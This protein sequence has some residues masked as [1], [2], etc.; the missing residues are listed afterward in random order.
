MSRA[1][2]D[3]WF[4]QRR[5]AFEG[6]L[7]ARF[8]A[9]QQIR[10]PQVLLTHTDANIPADGVGTVPDALA[11]VTTDNGDGWSTLNFTIGGPWLAAL[12][13]NN[14]G[15]SK[16]IGYEIVM[17]VREAGKLYQKVPKVEGPEKYRLHGWVE[18]V[19]MPA[20]TIVA[21]AWA[22]TTRLASATWRV[23]NT[24]ISK[25]WRG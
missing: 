6:K 14:Y 11:R 10:W 7:E 22:A 15:S 2:A 9:L 24:P 4:E 18:I 13:V 25:L 19:P 8:N 5:D 1:A 3:A 12:E 17:Y 16:G 20:E 21:R 23:L